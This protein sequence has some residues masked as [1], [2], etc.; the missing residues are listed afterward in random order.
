MWRNL[1]QHCFYR[2]EKV[3]AEEYDS[4]HAA[5]KL[6]QEIE[7]LGN[8]RQKWAVLPDAMKKD[9]WSP[10]LHTSNAMYTTGRHWCNRDGGKGSK[11][12][13]VYRTRF[14][15]VF[16]VSI[17]AWFATGA[18]CMRYTNEGHVTGP[19]LL[20]TGIADLHMPELEKKFND[21]P[22]MRVPTLKHAW[23]AADAWINSLEPQVKRE[24]LG[25]RRRRAQ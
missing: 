8:T 22:C 15:F 25:F 16:R 1:D 20:D 10:I 5:Q 2:S 4:P 21:G 11:C 13:P 17:P 6:A 12:I 18:L 9:K 7:A 24:L 23:K 3:V 19:F 14:T